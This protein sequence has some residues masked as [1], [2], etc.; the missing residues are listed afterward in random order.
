MSQ[1]RLSMRKALSWTNQYDDASRITG[2]SDLL[3]GAL[4]WTYG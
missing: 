2:I 3:N 1:T 4:S